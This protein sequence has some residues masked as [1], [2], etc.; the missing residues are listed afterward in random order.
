M[1]GTFCFSEGF[2]FIRLVAIV[3]I[4]CHCWFWLET[5]RLFYVCF[6]FTLYSLCVVFALSDWCLALAFNSSLAQ[7]GLLIVIVIN[8]NRHFGHGGPTHFGLRPTQHGKP[9]SRSLLPVP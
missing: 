6:V 1:F 9:E 2:Q 4:D 7:G 8:T 3:L 5:L